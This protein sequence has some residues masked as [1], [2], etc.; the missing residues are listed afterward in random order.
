MCNMHIDVI[1]LVNVYGHVQS[2]NVPNYL[3]FYLI[4]FNK[5]RITLEHYHFLRSKFN[6][7]RLKYLLI[8]QN[9]IS[10]EW[11]YVMQ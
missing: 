8:K 4:I 6:C 10:L 11:V 2:C 7:Q 3:F 1:L 9:C 5:M